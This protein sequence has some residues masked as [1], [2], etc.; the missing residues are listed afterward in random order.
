MIIILLPATYVSPKIALK[1]R[2]A[3]HHSV[4]MLCIELLVYNI[5]FFIQEEDISRDLCNVR[6]YKNLS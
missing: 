3:P 2:G 4:D 6:T 1:N 5:V